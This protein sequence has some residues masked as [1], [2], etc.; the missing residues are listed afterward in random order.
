MQPES[1]M[2]AAALRYHAKGLHPIPCRPRDKSAMVPWKQYQNRQPTEAELREWWGRT[3]EA[4]VALVLGRGIWALDF[5]GEGAEDLLSAAR[6]AVPVDAPIVET[7]NGKHVYLAASIAI[8][9]VI[10]ALSTNGGKPQIDVKGDGGYVM[11]PP[12]IHPSGKPY[13]WQ[14]LEGNWPPPEADEDLLEFVL[15]KARQH[16]SP[17]TAGDGA[18]P[19]APKWLT[20]ALQGVGEGRRNE[21]CARVAGYFLARGIARDV[22]MTLMAQW[23][24]R[25]TPA[26]SPAEIET[27]VRSIAQRESTRDRT[28]DSGRDEGQEP[29]DVDRVRVLHIGKVLQAMLDAAESPPRSVPS[30]FP[31][32]NSYLSGG[33]C[34]GELAYLGARPGIGKTTLALEIVRS[35]AKAGF[36]TLVVSREMSLIA[37]ARR[38]VAQEGKINASAIRHGSGRVWPDVV[39]TC[40]KLYELPV[41]LTDQA[42]SIGDIYQAFDSVPKPPDFV[43]VDYLQLVQSPGVGER[44]H[45]V[46]HVSQRLKGL[47][48]SKQIPVLCLSSLSRPASDARDKPPTLASLRESGNLEHDADIVM[49]MHRAQETPNEA[50]VNIAKN[51]DG[52]TGVAKL[53]FTP[54]TVSFAEIERRLSDGDR[55]HWSDR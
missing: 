23:G 45:Q 28:P 35:A 48:M 37:L 53:L 27:C 52:E 1:P 15:A 13:V 21:T 4:N 7:A 3:P 42:V 22:V 14:N 50:E 18:D 36:T 29:P 32:L 11:A 20:V 46:E 8:P 41:W 6:L 10:A 17:N 51:R 54:E 5:D 25:C 30:P 16:A 49:L 47:A 9:N 34:P 33:F 40:G 43:V 19:D 26:M 24:Q 39:R 31:A 38:M 44:R 55:P 2:L 12:S